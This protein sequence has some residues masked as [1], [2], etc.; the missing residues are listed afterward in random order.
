MSD[1]INVTNEVAKATIADPNSAALA[2][3]KSLLV[4][5]VVYESD[6]V[7]WDAVTT[8]DFTDATL[9][10]PSALTSGSSVV[11]DGV[12]NIVD[13]YNRL[14]PVVAP[15]KTSG[16]FYKKLDGRLIVDTSALTD[17]GFTYAGSTNT[18]EMI[19]GW[20]T[21]SQAVLVTNTG[22]NGSTLNVSKTLT[23]AITAPISAPTLLIPLYIPDYTK[24]NG[25]TI[26]LGSSSTFATAWKYVY[27]IGPSAT[28][29]L[30][31]NGWHLVKVGA[32]DWIADGGTPPTDWSWNIT[33]I[34][35][36][37]VSSGGGL[38]S[39]LGFDDWQLNHKA[40][41]KIVIITDQTYY[42]ANYQYLRQLTK[43]LA[44]PMTLAI[45]PFWLGQTGKMTLDQVKELVAEG[46]GLAIRPNSASDTFTTTTDYVNHV[47]EHQQYL[48]DNFGK[49]GESGA[50]FIVYNQGKYWLSGSATTFADMTIPTAISTECGIVAGRSTKATNYPDFQVNGADNYAPNILHAGIIGNWSGET[51]TYV[52]AEIDKAID[53]GNTIYLFWHD[54]FPDASVDNINNSVD[55]ASLFDYIALKR[56]QGLIDPMT[57]DAWYDGLTG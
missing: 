30:K 55:V 52:K 36:K 14:A 47:K 38:P 10:D 16:Q 44:I 57:W 25:I 6:G 42:A 20:F 56:S 46:A 32:G 49:I 19:T 22:S 23:T 39:V 41:A 8:G 40:K 24:V 53:R 31:Y 17:S 34:R 43:S 7:N 11:V 37:W 45:T 4:D 28:D 21:D 50:R 5:G 15:K 35:I 29:R 18:H 9:P 3:G 2:A 54:I 51:V 13:G 33:D 12:V 48:V 1:F 27:N 26:L